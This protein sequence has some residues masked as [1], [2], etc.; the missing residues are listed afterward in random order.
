MLKFQ[1]AQGHGTKV[2]PHSCNQRYCSSLLK[3]S[4]LV[5]MSRWFYRASTTRGAGAWR[6]THPFAFA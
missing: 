3:Q 5:T 1:D 4:F 2:F 6:Q